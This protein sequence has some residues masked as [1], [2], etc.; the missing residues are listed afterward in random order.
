M[1]IVLQYRKHLQSSQH[2]YLF[3]LSVVY[4]SLRPHGLQHASMS[5]QRQMPLLLIL[6]DQ[7]GR[8]I[9]SFMNILLIKQSH[10]TSILLTQT[11]IHK[12]VL[13]TKWCLYERVRLQL[14]RKWNNSTTVLLSWSMVLCFQDLCF[15]YHHKVKFCRQ[16]QGE[17]KVQK[18]TFYIMN[19]F[20]AN[21]KFLPQ[22][23]VQPQH[24]LGLEGFLDEHTG[25]NYSSRR[26][27]YSNEYM[28]FLYSL[29]SSESVKVLSMN[30]TAQRSV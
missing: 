14:N 16:N 3:S 28:A 8:I 25:V 23:S 15:I 5:T 13:L 26:M 21:G 1:Y 7:E 24:M 29:K 30:T 22:L 6:H 10:L 9:V 4:D 27:P 19:V 17:A 2:T 11:K 20:L 12:C 18:L